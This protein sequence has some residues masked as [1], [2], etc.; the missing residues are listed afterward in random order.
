MKCLWR[1]TWVTC[2]LRGPLSNSYGGWIWCRPNPDGGWRP[3]RDRGNPRG[4][5]DRR[6]GGNPSIDPSRTRLDHAE[7][8]RSGDRKPSGQRQR[9]ARSEDLLFAYLPVV[10]IS[11]GMKKPSSMVFETGHAEGVGRRRCSRRRSAWEPDSAPDPS[12][13]FVE[14][15]SAKFRWRCRRRIAQSANCSCILARTVSVYAG[16]MRSSKRLSRSAGTSW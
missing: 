4:R 6:G 15:A 3:R 2:P 10:T 11:A 12:A 7:F 8:A 1:D 5:R 9:P 13:R 16:T 14:H